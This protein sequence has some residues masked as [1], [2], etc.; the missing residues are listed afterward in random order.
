MRR[1]RFAWLA[2]A[3]AVTAAGC[4]SSEAG[5]DL[6]V[7]RVAL[8]LAFA[9]EELAVPVEPNRIIQLIPAPPGIDEP[10]DLASPPPFEAPPPFELCPTAP[11]GAAP[12]EPVSREI[13]N[14]PVPGEYLR[15]NEGTIGVTGGPF[16]IQLPFPFVSTWEIG[17]AET[18]EVPAPFGV[19][20][21]TSHREYDVRKVLA[22]GFEVIERMRLTPDALQLLSRTTIN[23]ESTTV[24]TPEPPIDVYVFGVE[25]DDWVSTGMDDASGTAMLYQGVIEQREIIDVC[26]ELIDTYRVVV[27]EQ[28]VNLGTGEVSGTSSSEDEQTVYSYA[29]H[30]GGLVVREVVHTTHSTRDPETGSPLVIELD[31]V[32]TLAR[33]EPGLG[34]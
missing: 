1:L 31:Y 9:V 30:L 29:T 33:V 27:T 10:A 23:Q 5:L 12:R 8:N 14:P 20:E 11:A 6:G 28:L 3:L 34:F 21:P 32:S 22:P 2:V 25:G 24:F 4:G 16:P 18:V 15:R 13:S 17:E 19:G 7:R 26:G